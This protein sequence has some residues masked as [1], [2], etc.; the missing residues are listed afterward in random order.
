MAA[1]EHRY[2]HDFAQVEKLVP[3]LFGERTF[4]QDVSELALG[5]NVITWIIRSRLI[6]SNNQSRATLWVRETCLI[7]RLQPVIVILITVLLSS[8]CTIQGS[9]A[10]FF[11]V[12]EVRNRFLP[13]LS[14]PTLDVFASFG[15]SHTFQ[16]SSCP[17]L[18][19][20]RATCFHVPKNA[21]LR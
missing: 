10:G 4:G 2:I 8:K 18:S 7:V 20:L 12:F 1:R 15:H 5:V 9:L 13:V 19:H 17:E 3:S 6:L 21:T 14:I 11:E 16:A